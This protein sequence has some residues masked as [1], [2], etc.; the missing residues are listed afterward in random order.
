MNL[1][2]IEVNNLGNLLK[3]RKFVPYFSLNPKFFILLI[4]VSKFKNR[5]ELN[6]VFI[7]VILFMLFWVVT[8][9]KF[10]TILSNSTR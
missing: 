8:K 5:F 6:L 2:I 3:G 7:S 10:K 4:E 1:R 9:I